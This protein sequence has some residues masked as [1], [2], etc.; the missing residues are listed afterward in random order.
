MERFNPRASG[1]FYAFIQ[2]L[3]RM[4]ICPTPIYSKDLPVFKPY[5]RSERKEV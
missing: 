3:F 5:R 4:G 1:V 2:P